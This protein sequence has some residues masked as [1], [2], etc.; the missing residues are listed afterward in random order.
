MAI[1]KI[2]YAEDLEEIRD[3]VELKIKADF[4]AEITPVENGRKAMELWESSGPFDLVIS[5]YDM[6]EMNGAELFRSIK[7]KAP[8]CPF[9]LL[10]SHGAD[11]KEF[12]DFAQDKVHHRSLL[13][14]DQLLELPRVIKELVTVLPIPAEMHAPGFQRI[15]IA[16]LKNL[17]QIPVALYIRLSEKKL[18]RVMAEGELF[19]REILEHYAK[20]VQFLYCAERDFEVLSNSFFS[21]LKSV[22]A[23]K[24][25]EAANEE[26]Q[27]QIQSI[28]L[29]HQL[30]KIRGVTPE[31]ISLADKTLTTVYAKALKS[32]E[33]H[34]VLRRVLNNTSSY[35]YVHSLTIPYVATALCQ[36]MEWTS[37]STL[38]TLAI[39]ALLHDATLD[40]QTLDR[41]F[42]VVFDEKKILE[43]KSNNALRRVYDHPMA[44]ALL[45]TSD[46]NL[47]PMV[48][49][50]I[51][52][53][54]ERPD[55]SG[56]PKGL[57]A[58]EID[59]LAAVFI[60][61]EAFVHA[62]HR[63][64]MNEDSINDA[65]AEV[66][67]DFEKGNFREPVKAL[68]RV[69]GSPAKSL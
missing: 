41:F 21:Q 61:S 16:A 38:E 63:R 4:D 69:F 28:E 51:E 39:T 52:Q 66:R 57:H 48:G 10:S 29:A 43:K 46:L 14:P 27:I 5:D 7:A 17:N 22:L 3:L 23:T 37:A 25:I 47:P 31:I 35:L 49:K 18:V 19:S 62:L 64:G 40:P 53:H 32:P 36:Q 30:L 2:L 24:K 6:P 42:G 54:H 12:A 44:S 11:E 20:K 1:M 13:K 50:I 65:V 67:T 55:G 15:A 58:T 9:I 8:L 33:I 45:I 68:V 60:V 56:Y 26:D 34:S 59:P